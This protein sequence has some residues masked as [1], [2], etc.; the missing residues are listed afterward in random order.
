MCLSIFVMVHS[1]KVFLIRLFLTRKDRAGL[2]VAQLLERYNMPF[3]G[4]D[5]K[6]FEPSKELMKM[7]ANYYGVKTPGF[8]LLQIS[9]SFSLYICLQ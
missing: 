3:T 8:H 9:L 4:A 2:E 1:M 5:S 7:M 6:F